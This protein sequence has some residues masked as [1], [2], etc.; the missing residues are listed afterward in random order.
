[1]IELCS[2]LTSG[3]YAQF[4]ARLIRKPRRGGEGKERE[5]RGPRGGEGKG[6]EGTECPNSGQEGCISTVLLI[7]LCCN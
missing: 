7:L 4:Y 3:D 6:R 1:M 5:G 2:T